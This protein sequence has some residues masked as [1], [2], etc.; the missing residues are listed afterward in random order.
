MLILVNI[1]RFIIFK[2]LINCEIFLV[3]FIW[4]KVYIKQ[5]NILYNKKIN[6]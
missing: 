4:I 3:K 1:I 6:N 5:I 2:N